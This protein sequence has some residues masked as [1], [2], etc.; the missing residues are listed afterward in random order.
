MPKSSLC[1]QADI[2]NNIWFKVF[3]DVSILIDK[4]YP[5]QSSIDLC[6]KY[7][8]FISKFSIWY[9]NELLSPSFQGYLISN[10]IIPT[11]KIILGALYFQLTLTGD[12]ALFIAFVCATRF[13]FHDW[14]S[15][16]C[17]Q[18]S[19]DGKLNKTRSRQKSHIQIKQI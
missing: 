18:S 2:N 11:L 7:H 6:L 4:C 1:D 17:S 5:A 8:E 16:T 15:V 10:S 12:W 9:F 13:L 19:V 14:S 3:F